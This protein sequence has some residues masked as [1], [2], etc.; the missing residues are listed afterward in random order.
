MGRNLAVQQP[1][2]AD[3]KFGHKAA[4]KLVRSDPMRPPEPRT[5]NSGS[6]GWSD[7]A[8]NWHVRTVTAAAGAAAADAA[9]TRIRAL[10]GEGH[11]VRLTAYAIKQVSEAAQAGW[12]E[13]LDDPMHSQYI[14]GLIRDGG[15]S[16]NPEGSQVALRADL[17]L[18]TAV[19]AGR[20][21]PVLDQ[22]AGVAA[23]RRERPLRDMFGHYLEGQMTDTGDVA[24]D[25]VGQ[26]PGRRYMVR[27]PDDSG[28]GEMVLCEAT[29]KRL[30]GGRRVA[31]PKRSVMRNPR[32][33]ENAVIADF[34][35]GDIPRRVAD[36]W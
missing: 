13:C 28:V 34:Q 3:G 32:I 9:A 19:D 22:A 29:S 16:E 23:F 4:A 6:D 12:D 10:G 2:Q 35:P 36:V 27:L 8:R 33:V 20:A 7:A 24:V 26:P 21:T 1:R 15:D 25:D 18:A 5:R 30:P 11:P 14:V 17:A 31:T